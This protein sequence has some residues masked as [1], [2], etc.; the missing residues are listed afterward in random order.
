MEGCVNE[1][2]VTFYI[3]ENII[4]STVIQDTAMEEANFLTKYASKVI[5]L[6]LCPRCKVIMALLGVPRASKRYLPSLEDYAGASF[7]EPQ[8]RSALEQRN[9]GT[10]FLSFFLSFFRSFVLSFFLS[11]YSFFLSLLILFNP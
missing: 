10:A 9:Y 4:L 11:F 3:A 6:S 5:H 1:L 2:L 8:N 7:Q